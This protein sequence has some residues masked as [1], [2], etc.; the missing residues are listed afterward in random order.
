VVLGVGRLTSQKDFPTLIRA[1]AEVHSQ[2]P[3]RL[4]ILGEG[5]DRASLEQLAQE[6]G[7]GGDAAL[8]GYVDNPYAY[9]SRAALFVLSSVHEGLPTVLIEALAVGSP[10][11]ATDCRSGP[12]EILDDGRLGRLVPVG[13]ATTMAGAIIAALDEPR[14]PITASDLAPYDEDVA[15][16]EYVHLFERVLARRAGAR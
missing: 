1:A 9:L 6:L 15:A 11:V 3:V 5:E 12:R 2:R 13:D 10:V 4:M 7:M 8:P 14:P 16:G